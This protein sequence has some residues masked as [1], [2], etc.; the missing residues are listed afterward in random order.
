MKL[1]TKI[2]IVSVLIVC[3]S[4]VL[5]LRINVKDP[6]EQVV[7][8]VLDEPPTNE[9]KVYQSSR[10]RASPELENFLSWYGPMVKDASPEVR[11]VMKKFDAHFR[12]G[13]AN[14]DEDTAL[15]GYGYIN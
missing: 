8:A 4:C 14:R 12:S 15:I 2:V 5:L 7:Q 1:K 6:V 13:W 9:D 10:K 3:A 11:A